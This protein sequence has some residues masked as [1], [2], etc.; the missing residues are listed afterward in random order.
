MKDVLP[1]FLTFLLGFK[2]MMIER[3]LGHGLNSPLSE[4]ALMREKEEL[5]SIWIACEKANP[6]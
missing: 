1:F 2:G 6:L 4:G 3:S 5:D